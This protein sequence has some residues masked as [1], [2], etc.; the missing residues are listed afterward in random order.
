MKKF[1]GIALIS[2]IVSASLLTGC[3]DYREIDSL[4]IVAGMGIDQGEHGKKYHLA[5]DVVDMAGNSSS[6]GSNSAMFS[7]ILQC[8]GDTIFDAIRDSIKLSG[9]RLYFGDCKVVVI[10]EKL[11]EKGIIPVTELIDRDAEFRRTTDLF[12]SRGKTA[13]EVLKSP[14][15]NE[16]ICS[17][18]IDDMIKTDKKALAEEPYVRL[19]EANNMLA[20]DGTALTLPVLVTSNKNNGTS[21]LYGA[22]VFKGSRLCG[23]LGGE[24]TQYLS[25]IKDNIRFSILVLDKKFGGEGDTLEIF[26][27][28]TRINPLIS[29]G[30]VKIAI[31]IKIKADLGENGGKKT[32]STLSG[33][34]ELEK[35]GEKT[36]NYNVKNLIKRVQ[37]KFDSDIFGFGSAVNRKDP[38]TWN[39]LKLKWNKLFSTLECDVHTEIDIENSATLKERPKVGS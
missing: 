32:Y 9:K 16:T 8:D 19:F 28:Q 26:R 13:T 27:S 4:A 11:A 34:E 38:A 1:K 18:E 12:I 37:K 7:K 20:S 25:F 14:P 24:E 29:N 39:E 33:F 6:S 5:I 31:S 22:A 36:V 30:K 17:F 10:S 15:M 35:I 3:W 21:Q 2:L 23:F